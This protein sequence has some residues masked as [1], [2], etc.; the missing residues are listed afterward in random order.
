LIT[1]LDVAWVAGLVEG[2]GSFYLKSGRYPQVIFQLNMTDED[3]VRK[4]HSLMGGVGS[5][6]PL[7]PGARSVKDQWRWRISAAAE[8]AWFMDLMY[9]HMGRRRAAKIDELRGRLPAWV[10][11]QK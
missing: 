5:V 7:A 11:D 10:R 1:A 4:A 9:P 3:V 8:V 6:N 2:E